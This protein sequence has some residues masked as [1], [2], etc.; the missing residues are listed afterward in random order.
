MRRHG[1]TKRDRAGHPPNAPAYGA[2]NG[3]GQEIRVRDLLAWGIAL[4]AAEVKGDDDWDE[5]DE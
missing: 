5:D 1:V 4:A 3:E 2:S